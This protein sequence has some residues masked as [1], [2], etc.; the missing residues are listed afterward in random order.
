MIGGFIAGLFVGV[1]C[2][3]FIISLCESAGKDE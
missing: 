2:G 1:I 3:V